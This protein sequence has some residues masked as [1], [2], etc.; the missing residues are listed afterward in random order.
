MQQISL[1]Q[2][3]TKSFIDKKYWNF[4]GVNNNKFFESLKVHLLLLINIVLV[5]TIM[6]YT[7]N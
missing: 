6:L 1:L 7:V 4:T 5:S 2:Q 3:K